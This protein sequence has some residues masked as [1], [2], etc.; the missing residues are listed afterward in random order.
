MQ[1]KHFPISRRGFLKNTAFATAA[2]GASRFTARSYAQV[3]GANNDLRLAVV[4]CNAMGRSH[5]QQIRGLSGVRLVALCDPDNAVLDRAMAPSGRGATQPSQ[6]DTPMVRYID[7]RKLLESKE[8]DAVTVA[9][10]NHWHALMTIWGVQAGKD[11]LIE[12]PT[13]HNVWEGR[14][15]LTAAR[16]Y[17]K[18]VQAGTMWRSMPQVYEAFEYA[19]SGK[20]GK[21][22]VSR[23]FCYKRR[24]SI[25]KVEGA[26]VCTVHL[27]LR[28]LV[29][30]GGK[31]S[32]APR[33]SPLRLALAM[34]NRQWR[35]RQPRRASA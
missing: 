6:T 19:K 22:L 4:G 12:K 24:A 26:G 1:T 10:P 7:Y 17:N 33:Q 9:T 28:S 23:G 31:S 5:I 3:V 15:T 16:K 18:I 20:L 34:G 32:D 25:G 27:R 13:S 21:V 11:V 8:I 29:R 14:Q 2:V 30:A 35:H